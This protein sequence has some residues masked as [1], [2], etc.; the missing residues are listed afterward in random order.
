MPGAKVVVQFVD[1]NVGGRAWPTYLINRYRPHFRVGDGEYLGVAFC[2]DD[3][4]EPIRAGA[5][6]SAE[7]AFVYAP[8]VDYAALIAGSQFR[9]LEGERIVGIGVV[10]ELTP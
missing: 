7:V 1:V 2:G 3:S 5:C 8:N 9:I 10:T 6:M 4:S